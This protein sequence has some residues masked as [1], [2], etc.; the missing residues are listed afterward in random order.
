MNTAQPAA[1]QAKQALAKTQSALVAAILPS[2]SVQLLESNAT[3]SIASKHAFTP[4]SGLDVYK[5]N[6]QQLAPKVLEAAYPVLA[7]LMGGEGFTGL[8]RALWAMHPPQRGDLAHWGAELADFLRASGNVGDE[9]YLP[10]VAALEWQLHRCATDADAPQEQA[11]L[12]VLM[13][14]EPAH[15]RMRLAPGTTVLPSDWPVASIVLAHRAA[16]EIGEGVPPDLTEAAKSLQAGVK[17]TALVWRQHFKPNVRI[18]MP[19]ESDFVSALLAGGSLGH[20]LEQATAL[21]F[22]AWLA[23]AVPDAL[24][25]SNQ[26]TNLKNEETL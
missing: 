26:E 10:D 8:A 24:W 13:Q 9:P 21:D 16:G 25:I 14:H 22:N 2:G 12:A 4:A 17:E 23:R 5:N 19:G 3:I 7:Q 1:A 15:I 20:A 18:C 6:L 11:T